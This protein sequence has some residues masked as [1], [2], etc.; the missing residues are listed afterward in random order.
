MDRRL[1]SSKSI[2]VFVAFFHKLVLI[3]SVYLEDGVLR[4]TLGFP[5]SEQEVSSLD[6]RRFQETSYTRIVEEY[7]PSSGKTRSD[8]PTSEPSHDPIVDDVTKETVRPL[9]QICRED[10]EKTEDTFP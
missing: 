8:L 9:S 6:F 3:G 2:S 4:S 5:S 1:L 10:T 7:T